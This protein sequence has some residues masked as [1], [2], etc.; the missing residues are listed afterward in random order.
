MNLRDEM[1]R[2][3]AKVD[4]A[5]LAVVNAVAWV[6]EFNEIIKAIFGIMSIGF[7][8]HRWYWWHK[9]KDSTKGRPTLD[10]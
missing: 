3:S 7:L 4:C 6:A 8:A 10:S 2:V 9:T 1:N 5:V